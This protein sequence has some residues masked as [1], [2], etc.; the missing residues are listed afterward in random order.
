MW[1]GMPARKK[2]EV[3]EDVF[4]ISDVETRHAV[5]TNVIAEYEKVKEQEESEVH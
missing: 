2:G 5:L 1:L 3:W 4:Y